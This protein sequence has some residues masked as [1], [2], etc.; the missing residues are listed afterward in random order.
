MRY[1]SS[2][3][4]LFLL[5]VACQQ[6]DPETPRIRLTYSDTLYYKNQ[7]SNVFTDPATKPAEAGYFKAIP[8]GLAIDSLTGRV[9][10]NNSEAGLRYKIYYISADQSRVL[11]SA[12]LIVS[13]ID[14]RDSIY[15][16][17]DTGPV[18]LP[19][20]NANPTL[21]L[22]CDDDD[23]DDDNGNGDTDDDDCEFDEKDTD[24]DG[25]DEVP[26]V[27]P[28]GCKVDVDNGAID[29]AGSI[30]AGL[31][32]AI[33]VNGATADFQFFYRLTDASS[34]NLQAITV[35][36]YYFN[37]RAD[38]PAE[39]LAELNNRDSQARDVILRNRDRALTMAP[40]IT[41]SAY[42]RAVSETKARPKRPPI[43]IIVGR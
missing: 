15:S 7:L 30:D 38:I 24:D 2:F 42:M 14:Y 19:I 5:A 28:S 16:L 6:S 9:N 22:P 4:I 25:D 39:L 18:A 27:N 32:G 13:G 17:A 21:S 8:L 29:L 26:G 31:L 3:A 34:R 12:K 11:D 1:L 10:V 37:T 23:S 41:G 40:E 20:Y 43:I 35:R 36:F 33:P